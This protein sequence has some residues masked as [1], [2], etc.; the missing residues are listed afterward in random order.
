[1]IYNWR[2]DPWFCQYCILN[3]NEQ[4]PEARYMGPEQVTQPKLKIVQ[5]TNADTEVQL[6]TTE[7]TVRTLDP[8]ANDFTPQETQPTSPGPG[9]APSPHT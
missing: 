6:E 7:N 8:L 9:P 2:K 3:I 4:S 5:V 1:M